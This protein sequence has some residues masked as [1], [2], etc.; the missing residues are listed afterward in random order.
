MITISLRDKN[1]N[2]NVRA[3]LELQ[4]S[5]MFTDEEI[6]GLYDKQVKSDEEKLKLLEK[7]VE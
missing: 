5:G 1:F 6:Q 4:K 3:I 7:E 2:E